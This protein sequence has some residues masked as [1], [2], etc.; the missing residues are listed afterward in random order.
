MGNHRFDQA[1]FGSTVGTFSRGR[2]NQ[3]GN[4]SMLD[5]GTQWYIGFLLWPIFPFCG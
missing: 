5:R 4:R 2:I 3:A 1:K